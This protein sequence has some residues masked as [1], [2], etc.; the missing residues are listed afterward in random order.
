MAEKKPTKADEAKETEGL[1]S[2]QEDGDPTAN[3][4]GADAQPPSDAPT[5]ATFAQL[6]EDFAYFAD[7]AHHT[8]RKGRVISSQDYNLDQMLAQEAQLDGID[9]DSGEVIC[10]LNEL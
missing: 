4:A 3:A 7:G 9:P 8:L 2:S 5:G 1:K 6:R 10:N